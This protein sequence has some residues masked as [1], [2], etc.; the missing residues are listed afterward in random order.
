MRAK[1]PI[2]LHDSLEMR[3]PN[4]MTIYQCD[5]LHHNGCNIRTDF[6]QHNN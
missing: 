6:S 5:I 4:R 3:M 1:T 2:A